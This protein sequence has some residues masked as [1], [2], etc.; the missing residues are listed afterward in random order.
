[1][2]LGSRFISKENCDNLSNSKPKYIHES[3]HKHAMTRQRGK[4]GRFVAKKETAGIKIKI[5]K[6]EK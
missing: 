1:L 2:N 5:E 4:G 3:R 6:I